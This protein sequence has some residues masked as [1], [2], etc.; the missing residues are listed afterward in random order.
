MPGFAKAAGQ[1]NTADVKAAQKALDGWVKRVLGNRDDPM[2]AEQAH[3][4]LLQHL[5]KV[6]R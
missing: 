1:G 6:S 3:Q 4:E 2:V 5:V